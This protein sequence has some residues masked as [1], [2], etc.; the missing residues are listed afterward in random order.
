MSTHCRSLCILL[1]FLV[2]VLLVGCSNK[3]TDEALFLPSPPPFLLSSTPTTSQQTIQPTTKFADVPTL[4]PTNQPTIQVTPNFSLLGSTYNLNLA[5]SAS[6][7]YLPLELEIPALKVDAPMLGVG[8]TSAN[9]MDAPKGPLDDPI[10][11]TAFWYRGSSIPGDVGTATIAGHVNDLIGRPQIFASLKKL[12]PGDL[13]IIHKIGTATYI[14]FKVDKVIVY[15]TKESSDPAVLA[16]IYGAGP[17]SGKGPQPS[18]D[19][20]SHLTLITCAGNYLT[21]GEFD[22]HTVVYATRIG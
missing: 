16:Q 22:H 1:A 8:L 4:Q 10:W 12:K 15:S 13:I 11:H 14:Q 18:P 21:N 5:L 7:V 17:V 9:S 2:S 3:G 6:P 19:G 20:L